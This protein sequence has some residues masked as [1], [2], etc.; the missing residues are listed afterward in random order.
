MN[1][2]D[3]YSLFRIIPDYPEEGHKF[4]DIT[5]LL[6]NKEA[7]RLIIEEMARPYEGIV[8]DKVVGI[9][10]RGLILASALAFYLGC[11]LAVIR[12][13]SRSP[14]KTYNQSF[15]VEAGS[16]TLEIHTE[17]IKDH[18]KV[19][20]I[21]DVLG[22]GETMKAT[23]DLVHKANAEIMGISFLA[24]LSYLHGKDNI[25]HFPVYSL[26]TFDE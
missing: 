17:A 5:A 2:R 8:I 12:S 1:V 6:E 20:I 16:K 23:I 14:Y 24:E 11:G 19:V 9:D 26:L 4:Y 10:A 25:S 3:L 13:Q 15:E 7:L 22:S 21:D 18:E